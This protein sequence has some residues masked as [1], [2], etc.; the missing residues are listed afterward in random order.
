MGFNII[1]SFSGIT[2]FGNSEHRLS[3]LLLWSG[4]FKLD[5]IFSVSE[6][7]DLLKFALSQ[8]EGHGVKSHTD[9]VDCLPLRHLILAKIRLTLILFKSNKSPSS[10]GPGESSHDK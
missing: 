5:Y 4:N 2:V 8:F 7:I 10:T 6:V 1:C 9:T 3:D